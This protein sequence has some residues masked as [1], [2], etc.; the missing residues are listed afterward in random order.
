MK[1]TKVNNL[2]RYQ[3]IVDTY[4]QRGCLCND[5]IQQEVADIVNHNY[6]YEFCGRNNAFLFVQKDTCRR[7]YY[8]L[9]DLEE[10]YDFSNLGD[11][12]VEIIFRGNSGLPAEEMDYLSKCGFKV[13][14]RRDQY[15]GIYHELDTSRQI[16]G[17]SVRLAIS[18]EEVMMAC[19]LFNKLFDKYSGDFIS[20][21]MVDEL[22]N[23]DS[24]LVAV[25]DNGN[26]MG[27]LH[28]TKIRNVTWASHLAVLSKYR[29]RGIGRALFDTF[30][31]INKTDERSRYMLWVQANNASAVNM[32]QKIGFKYTNK[33]TISMLKLN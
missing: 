14:L 28:Q 6:L 3:E 5:Y 33:S 13:N 20:E 29:N 30:I 32:Y 23:N 27:A 31:E 26:F 1:I 11:L 15:C 2:G 17:I 21:V 4:K 18:K 9:N 8:Y 10:I 25:D 12:L 19:D 22:Y 16:A 7:V 24:I